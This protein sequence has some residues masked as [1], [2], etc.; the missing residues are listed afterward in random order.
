MLS[1][2]DLDKLDDGQLEA[3]ISNLGVKTGGKKSNRSMKAATKEEMDVSNIDVDALVGA[4]KSRL[5]N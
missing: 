4:G 2:K 1:V 3:H 5:P